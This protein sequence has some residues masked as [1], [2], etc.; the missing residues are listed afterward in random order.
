[1]TS[2]GGWNRKSTSPLWATEAQF[3]L[4]GL[5]LEWSEWLAWLD[6]SAGASSIDDDDKEGDANG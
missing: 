1:M 6:G 5:W 3:Q 2:C 4:R